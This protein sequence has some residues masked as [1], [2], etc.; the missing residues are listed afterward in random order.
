MKRGSLSNCSPLDL[1]F[2]KLE[3][4]KRPG[5]IGVSHQ[6]ARGGGVLSPLMRA[7]LFRVSVKPAEDPQKNTSEKDEKKNTAA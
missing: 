2:S 7:D 3:S 6:K 4:K 5:V 1:E